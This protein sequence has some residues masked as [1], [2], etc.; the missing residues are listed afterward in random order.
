[1]V[2]A[3]G[4]AVG[5]EASDEPGLY[6]S[7][8]GTYFQFDG[9][10]GIESEVGALTGRA[11]FKFNRWLSLE[12]DASFGMDEGEFDFEGDED[13]FDLDDNSDGDVADVINAPGDFGMDYMLG[14]FV[15]LS[16][17]ISDSVEL[18][19]R[20]G[21]SFAEVESTIV[22]PGGATL[23]LGDSESGASVG[24]GAALHLTDHQSVRLDYTYTDFDLA[25]ANALGLMYQLRF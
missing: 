12:G 9:D 16:A 17:P 23:E 4:A 19:G 20:A 8:G 21:Y 6:V 3:S 5:Q 15:R 14:A 18:Y 7:G 2:L 13:D 24:A 25:E 11:G 1:M 22:T 10:N